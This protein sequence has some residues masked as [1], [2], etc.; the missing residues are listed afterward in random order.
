VTEAIEESSSIDEEIEAHEDLW[1]RIRQG[2]ALPDDISVAGKQKMQQFIQRYRQHPHDILQ[3][4]ESSALYLY[5]IVD[6]LEKQNMPT[7]LALL[8][9][10]ESRYDPFAY[11]AGRA[12]GLWQFIPA[13]GKRFNLKE[14]WWADERRNII[15]STQ[16]A[17]RYLDYLYTYFD[18]DW[19]LAIAAYNA[20]EG[21]IRKAI[22]KNQRLGKPTDYWS[23]SLPNE[24]KAYIPKLLAWANIIA[25][26][27][28]YT[29]R[30]API[31]NTPHFAAVNIGSQ[32]DL[33][34]LAELGDIEIEKIYALNPEYNQWATDPEEPHWLLLPIEKVDTVEQ[35]LKQH[36]IEDRIQW[37]RYTVKPND[38]L[39]KIAQEYN[40]SVANIKSVNKLKT[41]RIRVGSTL[42]IP[43][44]SKNASF[45]NGS[46]E[47]RLQKL[48]ASRNKND[49]HRIEHTVSAGE[50]LWSIAKHYQV[51]S[52]AI[53]RWNNMSPKDTLSLHK[54]LII[55]QKKV[56]ETYADSIVRKVIYKVRN[57]DNLS[58][59]AKKFSV[60]IKDIREW[61][62]IQNNK[63]IKPGQ[64]L[65]LYITMAD[66]ARRF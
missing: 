51:N 18:E 6:E 43:Q 12:S 63:Y 39:G 48:Q 62:S 52:H 19:L 45:Y 13:T 64:Q 34:N 35:A 29:L 56:P 11:S 41:T 23:L 24:T 4:T 15:D 57:G 37:L 54:K 7:E 21:T 9:F 32:I 22:K 27:D 10:V 20:G 8:P 1:A 50:T 5:Y 28:S 49:Q 30:L 3:Q 26:P 38:S 33:A 16:S 2:Y 25:D 61:N 55:W 42:L 53:A 58:I 47:Q 31:N 40:T 65:R 60:D 59:I 36:P 14:N 46:A 44:A 17:I 66:Q